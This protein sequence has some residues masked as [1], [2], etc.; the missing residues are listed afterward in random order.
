MFLLATRSGL[1]AHTSWPLHVIARLVLGSLLLLG[2]GIAGTFRDLSDGMLKGVTHAI[3]LPWCWGLLTVLAVFAALAV[4]R[5]RWAVLAI[6]SVAPLP[7]LAERLQPVRDASRTPLFQVSFVLQKETRGAE[8][9]TAFALG[10]EGVLVGSE[11]LRLESLSLERPPAPFELTLHAVERQGSL[12]LA[13]QFNTDLFDAATAVSLLD[14]FALLLR[15][16]VESPELALSALPLLSAA[17]RHQLDRVTAIEWQLNNL[18]ILDDRADRAA[19]RVQQHC[20]G[21]HLDRLLVLSHS[22]IEVNARDLVDFQNDLVPA[23]LLEARR[24][25]RN[26]IRARQQGRYQIIAT[27]IR[28]ARPRNTRV[29]VSDGDRRVGHACSALIRNCAGH[30]RSLGEGSECA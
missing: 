5:R 30:L 11:D 20:R 21:L 17:E 2:Y 27:S 18:S 1:L 8:G 9:L 24:L 13:L 4:W 10:E 23:H 6:A 25:C 26:A 12:S 28:Y 19:L 14:R 3:N 7:L 16:V 29:D 22:Q 15:S